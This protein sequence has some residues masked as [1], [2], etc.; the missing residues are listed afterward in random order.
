M[1]RAPCCTKV[2][3]HRGPWSIREDTLLKNYI[4]LHGE[5][6]WRSLPKKAGLLRCGK[7]CRLRWMN[8]LRPDI[9]RGNITPDEDDLIVRLHALLGN[10]W[11][12]IAGRLPG[13]TDNE[14]KNYWNTHIS[15]RLRS[16]GTDPDSHKKLP[17]PPQES[18]KKRNKKG[19]NKEKNMLE[20]EK[21]KVH[22][23]KPI[24][25]TL[26]SFSMSRKSRIFDWSTRAN[27]GTSSHEGERQLGTEFVDIISQY[28][29]LKDGGNDNDNDDVR[30]L[31]GDDD[32]DHG[33]VINGTDLECQSHVQKLYDEYLELLKT[34]GDQLQS[35]S[36][37]ES[38]LI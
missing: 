14:I 33:L 17:E 4:Q 24:R 27:H 30:F 31:L 28:S 9:K 19:N 26:S 5:G 1:G 8:Y 12:L 25:V 37:V 20:T 13:R 7:S 2:G 11:S 18:K 29:N 6:N 35:D 36:F 34:E 21:V 38:L 23:P 16:Q 22:N 3:L 15:K 32:Q 10:R